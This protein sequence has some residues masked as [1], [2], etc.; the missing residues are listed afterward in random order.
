MSR[1]RLRANPG[2]GA[3]ETH[4]VVQK[5]PVCHFG[6]VRISGEFG[7]RPAGVVNSAG[8]FFRPQN[9]PAQWVPSPPG[10]STPLGEGEGVVG[11]GG[12]GAANPLDK[13]L[14]GVC[15]YAQGMRLFP[16]LCG[17]SSP[18]PRHRWAARSSRRSA[19]RRAPFPAP[20]TCSAA[21]R[22]PRRGWGHAPLPTC[23]LWR[24]GGRRGLSVPPPKAGRPQ[25]PGRAPDVPGSAQPPSNGDSSTTSVAPTQAWGSWQTVR[26][27]GDGMGRA[28]PGV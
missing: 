3:N 19:L 17:P 9:D 8:V 26:G 18:G 13:P 12:G 16:V 15:L 21:W 27:Q 25:L 24:A 7:I 20:G 1:P 4:W 23:L 28:L 10:W 2:G 14:P 22:W 11:G 6:F 5:K